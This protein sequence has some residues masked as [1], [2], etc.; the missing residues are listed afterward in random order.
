MFKKT[1]LFLQDGIPYCCKLIK[2]NRAQQIENPDISIQPFSK[3][4]GIGESVRKRKIVQVNIPYQQNI[5][6]RIFAFFFYCPLPRRYVHQKIGFGTMWVYPIVIVH[7]HTDVQSG[8]CPIYV[9]FLSLL[10]L[11]YICGLGAVHK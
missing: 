4:C 6:A 10:L 11:S 3:S 5:W 7:F 9:P 1:A 2:K 8:T